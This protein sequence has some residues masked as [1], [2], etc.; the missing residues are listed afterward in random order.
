VFFRMQEKGLNESAER[1]LP[2]A[3]RVTAVVAGEVRG[4]RPLWPALRIAST[5][6]QELSRLNSGDYSSSI[7]TQTLKTQETAFFLFIAKNLSTPDLRSIF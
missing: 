2:A 7:P 1:V 6:H 5:N 4:A 3:A